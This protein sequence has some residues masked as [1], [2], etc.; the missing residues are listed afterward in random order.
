MQN[1]KVK[2]RKQKKK[3][4]KREKRCIEVCGWGA[5]KCCLGL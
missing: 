2:K 1:S 3:R 5:I 4:K